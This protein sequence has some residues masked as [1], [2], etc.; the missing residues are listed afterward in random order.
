[1]R[2]SLKWHTKYK[3]LQLL[4]CI[5][6]FCDIIFLRETSSYYYSINGNIHEN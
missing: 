6:N 5:M 1:M 4:H 3:F 2:K